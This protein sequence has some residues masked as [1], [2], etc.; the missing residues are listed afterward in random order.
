M[1]CVKTYHAA[2]LVLAQMLVFTIPLAFLGSKLIGLT[3]VFTG[4][5]AGYFAA[6][7]LA[8]FVLRDVIIETG[9][10]IVYNS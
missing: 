9:E 6:G 7:A 10:E 3:G 1:F 2:S 8:I 5:A 4:M